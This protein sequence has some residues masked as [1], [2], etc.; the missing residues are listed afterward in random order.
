MK[1]EIQFNW[2]D[3][4]RGYQDLKSINLKKLIKN[5]KNVNF[6]IMY[7][8]MVRKILIFINYLLRMLFEK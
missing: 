7:Y 4:I 3:V 2:I 1:K 6:D 8:E 5:L